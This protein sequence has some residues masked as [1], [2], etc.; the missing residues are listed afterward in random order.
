[1]E[2]AVRNLFILIPI[3]IALAVVRWLVTDVV[4]AVKKTVGSTNGDDGRSAGAR[5]GSTQA[6]SGHLVRDPLSGTYIDEQVAIQAE[7]NGQ[8]F[9]FESNSN[10]DE[11]VKRA[12]AGQA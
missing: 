8:T 11:Y 10:R 7:V 4:R 1:V 3:G 2:S 5:T 12:R 6:K 9:F